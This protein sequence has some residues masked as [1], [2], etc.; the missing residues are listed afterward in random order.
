MSFGN[1]VRLL[2]LENCLNQVQ[3]AKAL[4]TTKQNIYQI[5]TD[6]NYPGIKL[7]IALADFFKVSLDYLFGRT[8]QRTMNV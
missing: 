1:R 2:R 8:S 6:K 5:E 4:G 7:M 3:L